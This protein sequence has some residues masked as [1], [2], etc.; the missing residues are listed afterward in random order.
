MTTVEDKAKP[1]LAVLIYNLAATGV[2]RNAIRIA[3]A[4]ADRGMRTELWLWQSTGP[5]A[6]LVPPNVKIVEFGNDSAMLRFG[7]LRRVGILMNIPALAQ[8]I[9]KRQPR[10]LLSAGNRCHL[11][12]SL[13]WRLAGKPDHTI[14]IARASNANPMFSKKDSTARLLNRLDTL[15]FQSFQHIISVSHELASELSAIRPQLS[16]RMRV[17][18]NGVDMSKLAGDKPAAPEH[19]FFMNKAG[20]VLVSAG[21]ITRQKN[22]PLL[23]DAMA[24]VRQ[25]SP[26]ARLIILGEANTA[27]RVKLQ[28]QIHRLGLDDAVDLAGYANDPMRY[29]Q[30]A[31]AYV[32]SS[33]WEGASNSLLEAMACGARIIAT[34][35]PT[36]IRE[37]LDDGKQGVIA[38]LGDPSALAR[39]I[40]QALE[41]P[42]PGAERQRW[43][44]QFDLGNCLDAYCGFLEDLLTVAQRPVV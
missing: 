16:S 8:L 38:P 27:E 35:C 9:A 22:F 43:M 33:L 20:P 44:M 17:I 36:G 1:D 25:T 4:A 15:K 37:L 19:A 28:A 40:L 23:V 41:N 12:W 31:D 5:F 6:E 14:A 18:P 21:T 2:T 30:H 3:V 39:C 42:K 7:H 34:D 24:I 13:A 10:I 32:L 26:S 29:F 11:A